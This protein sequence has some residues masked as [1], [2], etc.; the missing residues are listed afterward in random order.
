MLIL[1]NF[2][3]L[4]SFILLF[5][6]QILSGNYYTVEPFLSENLSVNTIDSGNFINDNENYLST[7]LKIKWNTR[8]EKFSFAGNFSLE[9]M[10]GTILYK[11]DFLL[12]EQLKINNNFRYRLD[13]GYNLR[14]NINNFYYKYSDKNIEIQAGFYKNK[15]SPVSIWR[16]MTGVSLTGKNIMGFPLSSSLQIGKFQVLPTYRDRWYFDL[17]G[18]EGRNNI[19]FQKTNYIFNLKIYPNFISSNIYYIENSD[20]NNYGFTSGFDIYDFNLSGGLSVSNNIPENSHGFAKFG[21][22]KYNNKKD[23]QIIMFYGESSGY[24]YDRKYNEKQWYYSPIAPITIG[25]SVMGGDFVNFTSLK[26]AK[27]VINYTLSYINIDLST[28]G[29]WNNTI[30]YSFGFNDYSAEKPL[31]LGHEENIKFNINFLGMYITTKYGIFTPGNGW[32][33]IMEEY[34]YKTYR[35][36]LG[37]D[38]AIRII[39]SYNSQPVQRFEIKGGVRF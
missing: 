33:N 25:G 27:C 32:S 29:Y 19:S 13:K 39:D 15:I 17:T 9:Y 34:I 35:S 36:D 11:N 38:K 26:I 14:I 22:I 7:G 30:K 28:Y 3:R 2:L 12:N 16:T 23:L 5:G 8:K 6:S 4:S 1:K 37:H 10:S 24:N 18:E 21:Q 20:I 31:Y